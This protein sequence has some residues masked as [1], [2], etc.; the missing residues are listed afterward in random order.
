M[1]DLSQKFDEI[2][3]EARKNVTVAQERMKRNY[4]KQATERQLEAG[5]LVLILVPS[6]DQ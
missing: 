6:S 4:D 3:S 5:D 1:K 2:L